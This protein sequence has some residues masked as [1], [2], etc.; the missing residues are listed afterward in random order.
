M[1]GIG[2]EQLKSDV[3]AQSRDTLKAV[4]VRLR[5]I[6]YIILVPIMLVMV[7]GTALNIGPFDAYTVKKALPRM[8]GKHGLC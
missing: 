8:V 2:V 3:P 6:A 7:I 4:W 5:D 1:R